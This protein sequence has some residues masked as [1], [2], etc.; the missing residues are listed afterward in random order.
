MHLNI[1]L[2]NIGEWARSIMG[3]EVYDF[4]VALQR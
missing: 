2:R 4:S 1:Q 3:G